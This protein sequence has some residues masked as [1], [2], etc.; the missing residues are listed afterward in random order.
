M[1]FGS[2]WVWNFRAEVKVGYSWRS[3]GVTLCHGLVELANTLLEVARGGEHSSFMADQL[4][5]AKQAP[6]S[7]V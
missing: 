4:Q 1:G 6:E 2:S 7:Y 5:R 3:A